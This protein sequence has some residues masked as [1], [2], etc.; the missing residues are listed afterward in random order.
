MMAADEYGPTRE[1][2][3]RVST[4]SGSVSA[5]SASIEKADATDSVCFNTTGG[6]LLA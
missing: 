1:H 6:S 5:V 2:Y 3:M 4:Q